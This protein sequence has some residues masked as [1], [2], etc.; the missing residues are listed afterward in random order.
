MKAHISSSAKLW[1]GLIIV[2]ATSLVMALAARPIDLVTADL[3]R[4]LANGRWLLSGNAWQLLDQNFYAATQSTAPFINHHWLSG[5]VLY[6]VHTWWGFTGLSLCYLALLGLAYALVAH[7]AMSGAPRAWPLV[8]LMAPLAASRVEVRPEGFSLF[9]A[10]LFLWLLE[11]HRR[12]RLGNAY[13]ACLPV[14]MAVWVNLHIYFV[15]GLCMLAAYGAEAWGHA[16][17]NPGNTA[18]KRRAIEVS[19]VALATALACLMNPF[20]WTL[21]LFPLHIFDNYEY[22]IVENQ[23]LRFLLAYGLRLPV[24]A[25]TFCA[26]GMLGLGLVMT[27]VRCPQRLIS[28]SLGI[29]LLTAAMAALALRNVAVFG[30]LGLP[31]LA[32]LWQQPDAGR[33]QA[34]SAN[35][36]MLASLSLGMMVYGYWS[37]SQVWRGM[38]IG[39]RPG[40]DGSAR[41]FLDNNLSGPLFNDYDIGGYLIYY[42][43]PRPR[44]FVDNRPEAYPAAFLRDEYVKMQEDGDFWRVAQSRYGFNSIF[45]FWHDATPAAQTFLAARV[46]DPEWVP[47]Y[48]DAWAL[49][50]VR[51]TAANAAL[52]ERFAIP[53][54]RFTVGGVQV[55]GG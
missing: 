1:H 31:A 32:A 23:S 5:I 47:V 46:R 48:V 3:G 45:F 26:L 38:G 43:H 34:K 37:G 12:Q 52:I 18:T 54:Q 51:N 50:L 19:A 35:L 41:F 6:L 13:L 16:Y 8:L 15:L 22:M 44:V 40:I 25:P 21:V 42:L 4:H 28:A 14:L 24:F 17:R 7:L 11:Q 55:D 27:G 36:V 49:I 30:I 2:V 29:A 53:R 39:L 20:G 9:L 10:A 33:L